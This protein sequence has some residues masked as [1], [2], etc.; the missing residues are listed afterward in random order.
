MKEN[1]LLTGMIIQLLQDSSIQDP[2]SDSY[3]H[4]IIRDND[5]EKIATLISESAP[6][7]TAEEILDKHFKPGFFSEF[8]KCHA[9]KAMEEYSRQK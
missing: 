9:L 5:F 4:R 3:E 7:E 1:P 6:K 8:E 2:T